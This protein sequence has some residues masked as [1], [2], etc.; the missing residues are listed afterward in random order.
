M[1]FSVDNFK[2]DSNEYHLRE[3]VMEPPELQ[4]YAKVTTDLRRQVLLKAAQQ[5]S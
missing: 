2:Q 5:Q 3:N 4:K 1:L